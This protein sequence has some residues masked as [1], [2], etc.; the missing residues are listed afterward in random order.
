V[1]ATAVLAG[2]TLGQPATAEVSLAIAACQQKGLTIS[3]PLTH[4]L[5]CCS[6]QMLAN[7]ASGVPNWQH[8]ASLGGGSGSY[9]NGSLP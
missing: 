8:P 7:K 6:A 9:A 5:G 3:Q 4:L 2:A 1:A